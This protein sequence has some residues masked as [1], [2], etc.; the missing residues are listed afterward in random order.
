MKSLGFL[1]LGAAG[2]WVVSGTWELSESYMHGSG[3][4]LQPF[5]SGIL[6]AVIVICMVALAILA[7]RDD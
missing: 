5:V 7:D 4:G 1:S 3:Y 2:Q 6:C